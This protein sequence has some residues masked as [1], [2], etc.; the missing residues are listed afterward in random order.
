MLFP[1]VREHHLR[2]RLL[3]ERFHFPLSP[4]LEF[5]ILELPKFTKSADELESDLD[6][7]LYFLRHAEKMDT[8]ALPAP[9][10]CPLVLFAAEELK[11]LTQSELERERYESRRKKQMDDRALMIEMRD[12][13][14]EGRAEGLAAGEMIGQIH[15]YEQLLNRPVT[16]SKDLG[17]LSLEDLSRLAEDLRKQ[18]LPRQ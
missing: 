12:A 4:D 16:P 8:A 18:L 10:Q 14:T 11:M 9:L 2:F 5:H 6:I 17:A 13:R 7:W 1:D 3:E 15:A